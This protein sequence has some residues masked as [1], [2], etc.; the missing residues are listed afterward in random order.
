M[1]CNHWPQ[2]NVGHSDLYFMVECLTYWRLFDII[3]DGHTWDNGS[4][5]HKDWPHKMYVDHWPIFHAPVLNIF[6]IIWC[7]D[8]ALGNRSVWHKDWPHEICVGQWPIFH[9]PVIF[10]SYIFKSIWSMNV[11]CGIVDHCD[12]KIDLIIICRSVTYISWS[13]DFA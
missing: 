7:S 8:V 13:I 6:K 10:I 2:N 3:Y 1:W 12:T 11:I 5:W 4:V 9:G